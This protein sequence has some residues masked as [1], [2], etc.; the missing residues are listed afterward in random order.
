MVDLFNTSNLRGNQRVSRASQPGPGGSTIT[1]SFDLPVFDEGND[2]DVHLRTD[3]NNVILTAYQ[4]IAGTWVEIGAVNPAWISFTPTIGWTHTPTLNSIVAKY[5]IINGTVFYNIK[6]IST[7]AGATLGVDTSFSLSL[8]ITPATNTNSSFSVSLL[9]GAGGNVGGHGYLFSFGGTLLFV[10][11]YDGAGAVM[12]GS[13]L[14]AV[15][16]GFYE[17]A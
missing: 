16:S 2:G 1:Y 3:V 7:D 12:A 11:K 5:K 4:K 6:Y 17:A 8:P 15:I 13:P 10:R 9:S 14:T